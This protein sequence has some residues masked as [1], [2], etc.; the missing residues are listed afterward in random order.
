MIRRMARK[1]LFSSMT[2]A[3]ALLCADANAYVISNCYVPGASAAC[4]ANINTP[5]Q[6][7]DGAGLGSFTLG[8]YIGNPNRADDGFAGLSEST[9][10]NAFLAAAASWSSVVQVSFTKLGDATDPT[11]DANFNNNNSVSVYFHGGAGDT[12]DG[13]GFDG[14]WD[15]TAGTGSI[16]AHAWGPSDIMTE[17]SAGNIHLDNEESWVTSGAAISTHSATIDLQSVLLHEIGHVLGLAHENSMGSG[18]SAPVMQSLYWGEQRSLTADDIAGV[19]TLYACAG[20]DCVTPCTGPD[21]LPD[22]NVPEPATILLCASTLLAWRL[23]R[24]RR[25]R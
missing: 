6:G 21:C 14:A 25:R 18:L 22:G 15:P 19:R 9:I 7:W 5:T 24:I 3:I 10:E 16:F 11:K 4:T 20:T 13:L 17:S 2:A 23:S 12:A 8:Y 1:V